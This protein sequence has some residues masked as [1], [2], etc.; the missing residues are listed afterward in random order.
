MRKFVHTNWKN[1]S[2]TI[3]VNKMYSSFAVKNFKIPLR[4]IFFFFNYKVERSKLNYIS[5]V[6]FKF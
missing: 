2:F 4:R 1:Y 3:D 5:I 6:M